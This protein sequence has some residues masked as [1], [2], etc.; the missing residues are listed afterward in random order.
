MTAESKEKESHDVPFNVDPIKVSECEK[1]IYQMFKD[2]NLNANTA[3]LV[4]MGCIGNV[5]NIISNAN[6]TLPVQEFNRFWFTMVDSFNQVNEALE[7]TQRPKDQT[8]V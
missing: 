6:G 1:L 8:D 3:S 4:L 5:L 2:K 7:K